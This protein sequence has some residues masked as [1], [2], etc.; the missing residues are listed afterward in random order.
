LNA[1]LGE[2]RRQLVIILGLVAITIM[3]LMRYVIQQ[4]IDVPLSKLMN[5]IRKIDAHD[6]S[7]SEVAS[8]GDELET[9][10]G[11]INQLAMTVQERES[12]L[13][14]S[15]SELEFLSSHDVLTGLPNRRIFTQRLQHALDLSVRSHSRL[16]VIFLDLDQF[17]LVNDTLGHDVGDELLLQVGTRLAT[18]MRKSDTL[19]RIGGDEFNIL[20]EN[21]KENLEIERLV[22]K[23]LALFKEPFNCFGHVLNVTASIGI[24]FYPENGTDAITLTKHADLA[25]YRSK[26]L[27]RN[28]FTFFSQELSVFANERVALIQALEAA[29]EAGDQFEVYYQAKVAAK[30][31]KIHSVEALLRWN[32]PLRGTISPKAFIKTAE[33]TGLILQ[34][35]YWVLEQACRDV[36]Y[37]RD[38]GIELGHVSVNI[39][40]VQMNNSNMVEQVKEL[41]ERTGIRTEQLELE[42]TESYIATNISQAIDMLRQFSGMGIGLAID[43]FG[44]GYSSMSYLQK[45]P[46]SRLKIDKSFVDELPD[47]KDSKA[48]IRAI[49]GLAKSFGLS[50][51]AEGVEREEQLE[52]LEQELCDEI[53]GYYFSKPLPL[54]AFIAKYRTLNQSGTDNIVQLLP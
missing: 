28:S 34:I 24:A 20:I 5:Q 1:L 9:I 49:I 22:C 4:L 43:D 15:M 51:T 8:T 39:S 36:V 29:I 12:S 47:S 21:V 11:N 46:V 26:E 18:A 27:G 31:H 42:I 2:S 52:F 25:M 19:A 38:M 53:Q 54:D 45:L 33:E 41:I 14:R 10:S 35:G 32:H 7:V 40:N 13:E 3:L 6:Y 30:T 16:S 50:I 44:T 37:L 17:K 23:Y 48:I